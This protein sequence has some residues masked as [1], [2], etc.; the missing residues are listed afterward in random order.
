LG[1]I[2][3]KNFRKYFPFTSSLDKMLTGRVARRAALLVFLLLIFLSTAARVRSYFMVLRFQR[4]LSGLSHIKID[5]TTE[6][7]LVRF[8]PY[9]VRSATEEKSGAHI[10][11]HYYVVV[12]NESDWLMHQLYFGNFDFWIPHAR[13]LKIA[14]WLGYRYISLHAQ[15]LVIDGS[16]SRIGYKIANAY[17]I[18]NGLS[19]YIS[20]R[21]VHGV[22]DREGKTVVTPADDENPQFRVSGDERSLHITY[23]FDAPSEQASRAFDINLSCFWSFRGCRTARDIAPLLWQYENE[24]QEKAFSRLGSDGPCPNRILAERVRYLPNLDVLLLDIV[25]VPTQTPGYGNAESGKS[26]VGYRLREVILGSQGASHDAIKFRYNPEIRESS[27]I[28]FRSANAISRVPQ[29]GDR[30]VLFTGELFES[31]QMIRDTPSALMAVQKAFPIPRRQED[32][33]MAKSRQ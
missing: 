20:V 10:E 1:T 6:E 15:L 19:D 5:K 17:T 18:P 31:C 11:R 26:L 25:R 21:S 3:F 28:S 27:N 16:V 7:E 24:I 12:S 4:V 14:D 30:V 22:W 33:I 32:E 23:A 13:A 8:V 29:L 2:L 9:L